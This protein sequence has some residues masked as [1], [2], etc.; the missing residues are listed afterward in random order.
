MTWSATIAA[1]V[2]MACADVGSSG[3]LAFCNILT[4]HSVNK[5]LLLLR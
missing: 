1:T 4:E 5:H 2:Q 3:C